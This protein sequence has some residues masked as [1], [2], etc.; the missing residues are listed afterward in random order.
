MDR[1]VRDFGLRRDSRGRLPSSR[2]RAPGRQAEHVEPAEANARAFAHSTTDM[3]A[4]CT[5]PSTST[6]WLN[7]VLRIPGA[8]MSAADSLNGRP[9]QVTCVPPLG[10]L[11]GTNS[12]HII[13]RLTD[14]RCSPTRLGAGGTSCATTTS[15]G[16][17]SPAN[18]PGRPADSEPSHALTA[19]RRAHGSRERTFRVAEA[20]ADEIAV[21]TQIIE[22]NGQRTS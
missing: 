14:A 20:S 8:D 5:G 22:R 19:S 9:A 10:A 21:A 15:A 11:C 16:L 13:S 4:V 3:H 17:Q 6:S 12:T 18:Q 7:R 1:V 2:Q